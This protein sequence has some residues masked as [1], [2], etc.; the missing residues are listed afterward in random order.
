MLRESY[1]CH[2]KQGSPSHTM[3]PKRKLA[4]IL[5]ADVVGYSRLMADDEPGTLRALNTS[6]D[7]FRIQIDAHHGRV[8]DTAGDSVLAE[9]AS[10]VEAVQCA[11]S[12]QQELHTSMAISLKSSGCAFALA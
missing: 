8:I 10:A 2:G 12:V 5:A 6:R 3:S 11:A 9:F 1:I 7:L 4:A